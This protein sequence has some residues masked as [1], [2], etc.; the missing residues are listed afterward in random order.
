MYISYTLGGII[1][2]IHWG[3]LYIIYTV[4]Y[5]ECGWRTEKRIS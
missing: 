5:T 2:H 1:Y 4:L 3:V